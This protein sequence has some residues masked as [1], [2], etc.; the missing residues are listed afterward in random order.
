MTCMV[1]GKATK[2][3]PDHKLNANELKVNKRKE[4]NGKETCVHACRAI[5]LSSHQRSETNRLLP[6][7]R[8]PLALLHPPFYSF[9]SSAPLAPSETGAA[10]DLFSSPPLGAGPDVPPEPIIDD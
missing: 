3:D 1:V 8:S 6:A 2:R 5:R 9:G 7:S 10:A 4:E